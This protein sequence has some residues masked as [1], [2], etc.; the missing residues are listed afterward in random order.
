MGPVI[1]IALVSR[2]VVL[3][4]GDTPLD[5][6]RKQLVESRIPAVAIVDNGG[7]LRGLVTRNA[8]LRA[9]SGATTAADVQ[10]RAVS[11]PAESSVEHAAAL[12]A[13]EGVDELVVVGRNGSVIGLI[14]TRDIARYRAIEA[15]S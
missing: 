10:S 12:M 1:S 14:T 13:I 9:A 4:N 7:T 15:G 3:V 8:V 11:V 5:R 2:P 6:L